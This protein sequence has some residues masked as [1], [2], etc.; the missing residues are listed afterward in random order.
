MTRSVIFQGGGTGLKIAAGGQ[1]P[2]SAGIFDLLFNSDIQP[3]RLW[4]TGYVSVPSLTNFNWSPAW[5]V[6]VGP[7]VQTPPGTY[8]LFMVAGKQSMA[9]G[10]VRKLQTP[11]HTGGYDGYGAFISP[12]KEFWGLNFV[13]DPGSIP[14]DQ[15]II[16]FAVLKNYW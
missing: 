6:S 2:A 8:P 10:A 1:D 9:S 5:A 15:A 16:N 7:V 11:F 3:L 14:L 13:H 12:S 4:G